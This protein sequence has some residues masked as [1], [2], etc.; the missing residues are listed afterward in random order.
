MKYLDFQNKFKNRPLIDIREV[1][2][3]F[4]DFDTRRFNEWQGKGYIK[5]LSRLFYVFSDKEINENETRFIANK[6]LEPSYISLESALRHYNLIPEIVYLNTSITTRKTKLIETPVGNFQYRVVKEKL[7]FGY[8]IIGNNNIAFK[9]AE[10]E[11][12]LLDFL[13]LRSDI[14]N[15]NDIFELRLNGETYKKIIDQNK[16]N[17]YLKI[18]NSS[19]L[20]K[21]IKILNKVLE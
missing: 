10:P 17:N 16:L 11:K 8:K 18:F 6:L 12:A 1:K 2:A 7:F 14:K 13:Y 9:I 19:T 21:K 15:E 20:N 5:K 3:V 4:S